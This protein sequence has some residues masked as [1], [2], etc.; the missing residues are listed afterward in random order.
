MPNILITPALTIAGGLVIFGATQLAQR[1][2]LDPVT[3]LMKALGRAAYV[4]T[5]YA[6][7]YSSPG[8]NFRDDLEFEASKELRKS[9][10]E[11]LASLRAV[12][13]HSFFC[14][15]RQVPSNNDVKRI[16]SLLIGLSNAS[17]RED[18]RSAWS[19]ANE[20]KKLLGM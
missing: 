15:L 20:L 9:A 16:A 7:V 17:V 12:H 11:L 1:F 4:V 2:G 13:L 14:L 18:A 10:S 3:D 6:N 8:V 19:E 5:Y